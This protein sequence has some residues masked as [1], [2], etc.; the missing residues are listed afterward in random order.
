MGGLRQLCK[1]YGRMTIQGVEWVWDYHRDE[2]RKKADMTKEE[3]AKSE[4]V[5]FTPPQTKKGERG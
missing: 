4:R 1:L 2:P 5:R 3:W